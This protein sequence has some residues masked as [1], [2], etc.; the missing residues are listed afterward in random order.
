MS[1][2]NKVDVVAGGMHIDGV[3]LSALRPNEDGSI[4]VPAGTLIATGNIISVDGTLRKV[5]GAV[6]DR[7]NSV[8]RSIALYTA[9]VEQ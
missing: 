5:I 1:N 4:V 3:R 2:P 8:E 6:S 9:P 7:V